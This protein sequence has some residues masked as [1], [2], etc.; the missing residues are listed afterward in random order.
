M[1]SLPEVQAVFGGALRNDAAPGHTPALWALFTEPEALA[2]RRLAAYRRNVIGNW[3]SA[4]ASSYPV[5]AQLLGAQRFRQLADQYIAGYPS[6]SGD[7]NDYGGELA[8]W[9]EAS[10]LSSERP[11]LPDMARLEWALLVAYGAVDAAVFDLAALA[12]IPSALQPNLR[13]H[14]WAGAAFIESPWP[15]VDIWQAHQLTEDERDSALA[16]IDALSHSA[17]CRALVVR[18]EG[19]VSALALTASEAAFLRALQ[20]GQTL[21]EAITAALSEDPAFNP[22]AT[23][24]AFIV[25][26]TLTGFSMNETDH[27]L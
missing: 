24:Q 4:L 18:S 13:L 8:A 17:P 12:E 9:L 19:R 26:R 6:R 20:S 15:L 11:Y 1:P 10:S 27:R 25:Q 21:A 23:L 22:G 3:R 14:I 2:E 7:L 5:L 16:A